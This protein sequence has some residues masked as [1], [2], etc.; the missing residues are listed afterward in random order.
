MVVVRRQESLECQNLKAAIQPNKTG[1]LTESGWLVFSKQQFPA[2]RPYIVSLIERS[3]K[4]IIPPPPL[5][6]LTILAYFAPMPSLSLRLLSIRHCKHF[7]QRQCPK[8][9]QSPRSYWGSFLFPPC[10]TPRASESRYVAGLHVQVVAH[11][12]STRCGRI[13]AI[14]RLQAS[15]TLSHG[16]SYCARVGVLSG[17]VG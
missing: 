16:L 8:G 10:V 2:L 11:S 4:M 9:Q 15:S 7:E 6:P 3:G 13:E 14:T 5:S 1:R 12:R 17:R